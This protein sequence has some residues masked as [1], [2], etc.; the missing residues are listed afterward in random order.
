MAYFGNNAC[1][2]WCNFDGSGSV[3]I[4]DSYQVSSITDNSSG[5][6][7][8][9]LTSAMADA[10]GAAFVNSSRGTPNGDMVDHEE[11]YI[12]SASTIQVTS[13]NGGFQDA[14]Y[15]YVGLFR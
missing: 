12:N 9:N 14:A 7:T 13:Y 11:C 15:I 10:N 1:E 2:R 5:Y 3:N 4:R 8:V 6:Y